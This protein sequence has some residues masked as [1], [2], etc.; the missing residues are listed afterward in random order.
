MG[1]ILQKTEIEQRQRKE[2]TKHLFL[3]RAVDMTARAG[4][5]DDFDDLFLF[6]DIV[7]CH[8]Y[9]VKDLFFLFFSF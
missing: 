9:L 6:D 8:F 7:L 3:D 2:T 4:T 1:M 5:R